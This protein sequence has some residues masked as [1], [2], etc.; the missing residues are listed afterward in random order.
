M[1]DNELK[2]KKYS[3][4]YG[5]LAG[6]IGVIFGVML[7]SMDLHYERGL[8]IQAVQFAIIA[9]FIIIGIIQFKKANNGFLKITQALKIGSAVGL[10]SAIIGTIYFLILSNVLEP[11][12]M[13]KSYEIAKVQAFE[14]NPKLTQEQWDQGIAFQKKLYPVFLAFGLVFSSLFGL[15]IG[16]IT[17]LIAK[18]DQASY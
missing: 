7:Y 13:A 11:D 16:L 14:T 10:I 15:I 3:L 2:T 12:F 6:L 18:K 8:A 4:Q 9:V 5:L 1:E 17:G